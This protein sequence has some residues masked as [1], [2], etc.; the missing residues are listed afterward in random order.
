MERTTGWEPIL[1]GKARTLEE[2]ER[3]QRD[4][5]D[6][7]CEKQGYHELICRVAH[8]MSFEEWRAEYLEPWRKPSEHDWFEEWIKMGEECW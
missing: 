8:K 5:Y 7:W 6:L 2:L 1:L 3:Y 4:A